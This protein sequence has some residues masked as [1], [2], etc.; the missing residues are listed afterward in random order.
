M[1]AAAKRRAKQL[2]QRR[3]QNAGEDPISTRLNVLLNDSN[4]ALTEATAYEAL[5]LA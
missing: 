2:Q 4:E 1:S 3:A 5:Q